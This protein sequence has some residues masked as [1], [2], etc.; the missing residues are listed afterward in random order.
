M[1]EWK[2]R[3]VASD[4]ERGMYSSEYIKLGTGEKFIGYALFRAILRSPSLGTTSSGSTIFRPWAWY[5]VLVP[6]RGCVSCLPGR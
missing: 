1:A 2:P 6:W 5:V 4:E 3:K